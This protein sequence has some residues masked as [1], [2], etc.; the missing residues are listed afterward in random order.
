[1]S[2]SIFYQAVQRREQLCERLGKG[3]WQDPIW[4]ALPR[5][6]QV[7][8]GQM[9]YSSEPDAKPVEVDPGAMTAK[10]LISTMRVDRDGD[11]MVP[12]GCKKTLHEY[13]KNPVVFFGHKSNGLPI[14]RTVCLDVRDDHGIYAMAKFHGETQESEDVY[15]LIECGE[16]RC[17][18]IGFFPTLGEVLEPMDDSELRKNEVLFQPWRAFK[19]LE[20]NLLEWSVVG[21]PANAD[22]LAIRLAKGF[23]GKAL[24]EP[25]RQALAPY[26]AL[27]RAWSNGFV[28]PEKQVAAPVVTAEVISESPV[29]AL[30]L[31]V[32]ALQ[33]GE[34][35]QGLAQLN[36]ALEAI[37]SIPG[38]A[39]V[40]VAPASAAELAPSA[41]DVKTLALLDEIRA[42]HLANAKRLNH[43]TGK[44]D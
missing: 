38:P 19:F 10:F 7:K 40:I 14:G 29:F 16:L 3:D 37:K 25:V 1:M 32:L 44:V 17:A 13:E 27:P 15:K 23:G 28:S 26:A 6:A 18:S 5:L 22:C 41:D 2:E 34:L 20:W 9:V 43:M 11:I 24:C 4:K 30:T 36:G 39:P 31:D 8:E 42:L 35:K 21:I 33:V 12:Q